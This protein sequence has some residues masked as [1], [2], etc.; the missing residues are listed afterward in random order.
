MPEKPNQQ[1]DQVIAELFEP[2]WYR[3]DE[4]CAQLGIGQELLEVCLRWEI[5]HVSTTDQDGQELFEAQAFARLSRGLRLHRDLGINWAGVA[6][7]LELLDR[8]E[9]LE[10]NLLYSRDL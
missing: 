4:L 9:D 7:A 2:D 1:I 8:I 10:Q 6:V 5:V 3:R